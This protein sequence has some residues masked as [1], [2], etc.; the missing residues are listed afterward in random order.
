MMNS[1]AC[2]GHCVRLQ[3]NAM[4]PV[5]ERNVHYWQTNRPSLLFLFFVCGLL[6]LYQ[7]HTLSV[8]S[9]CLSARTGYGLDTKK[10]RRYFG[11][12]L[13]MTWR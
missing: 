10:T 1:F 2:R 4:F 11:D 12:D 9:S 7:R 8:Y 3:G 5:G 6:L 13:D